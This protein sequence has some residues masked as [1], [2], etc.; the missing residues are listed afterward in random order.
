MAL[1]PYTHAHLNRTFLLSQSHERPARP[2]PQRKG[3]DLWDKGFSHVAGARG[4]YDC[5]QSWERL[6]AWPPSLKQSVR[7]VFA[8]VLWSLLLFG[9]PA[10]PPLEC[11]L[12]SVVL[13]G[14]GVAL[15]QYFSRKKCTHQGKHT[16][17]PPPSHPAS[18]SLGLFLHGERVRAEGQQD[19]KGA[20]SHLVKSCRKNFSHNAFDSKLDLL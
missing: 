7:T 12:K 10:F 5:T 18:P 20:S 6:S 11:A 14:L 17:Q 13:R 9:P 8:T 1:W 15:V 16:A 2:S 19:C 4:T 3:W